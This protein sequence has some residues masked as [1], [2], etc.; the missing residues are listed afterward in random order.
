MPFTPLP[1]TLSD[2]IGHPDSRN[3]HAVE[4]GCGEGHLLALLRRRGLDCVG[5]DRWPRV[6]GCA[7]DIRG[8]VLRPPLRPGSLDLV[9]A[10]NLVR[11]L[12][13]RQPSPAF[14]ETWLS[15]LK[16]GGSVFILEDEPTASSPAAAHYGALQGFLARLMPLERGPLVSRAS[17]ERRLTPALRARVRGSGVLDNA[18]PQDAAAAVKM[19][20]SGSPDAG[21]EPDLLAAAI[22]ADG[23]A[24]GRMWWC[25]LLAG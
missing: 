11:H 9:I 22:S 14:L 16:A 6:A 15:L 1:E 25:R 21:S 12:I 4:L 19:L 17:F 20:R 2:L 3:L 13:P 8:D 23:L 10:A 24:C 5:L 18:W 7:A